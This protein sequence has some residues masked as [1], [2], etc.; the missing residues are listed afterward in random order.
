[1]GIAVVTI[2]KSLNGEDWSNSYGLIVNDEDSAPITA[3]ELVSIGVQQ[4]LN[5]STTNS[6]DPLYAGAESILAALLGYERYL[7]TGFV[8][9]VSMDIVDGI[10]GSPVFASIPLSLTGL[11]SA[12]GAGIEQMMPG[13]VALLVNKI[14]SGVSIRSGRC[15]YR[16]LLFDAQVKF[17]GTAGIDWESAMGKQVLTSHFS[18]AVIATGLDAYMGT[19]GAMVATQ[20][21]GIPSYAPISATN[22]GDL[23]RVSLMS[24]FAVQKPVSRQMKRGRKRASA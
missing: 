11:W 23:V 1:M 10:K 12:S 2:T 17:S 21:L 19:N 15:F 6:T 18:N 24:D 14:P 8:N 4:P 5:I 3:E 20:A 22:K 7:H 13:N 9:F 16:S